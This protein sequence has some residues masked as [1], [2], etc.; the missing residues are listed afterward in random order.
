MCRVWLCYFWN[1]ASLA[2]TW[3]IP[4]M[5]SLVG[6]LLVVDEGFVLFFGFWDSSG[7]EVRC[8]LPYSK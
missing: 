8:C 1:M 2:A 6:G 7:T 5:P 3:P 4:G